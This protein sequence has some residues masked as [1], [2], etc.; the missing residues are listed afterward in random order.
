MHDVAFSPSGNQIVFVAHDSSITIASGPTQ[1][2]QV[3]YTTLLPFMNC[4][5]AGENNIVVAGHD[6]APYLVSQK[7]GTTWYAHHESLVFF[8][9]I[10]LLTMVNFRELGGKIDT[11]KKK[12]IAS[13]SAFNKFKQMDSRAQQ[14]GGSD[15]VELTTTHQNTITTTRAYTGSRD[16]VTQFSTSGV[17][18]KLVVWDLLNAGIAG[19]TL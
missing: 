16:R 13:N 4:F 10:D 7:N 19:L 2:I 15:A 11:G 12:E 6:C 9:I 5:W 1:P 3:I 18:G 14:S 8:Y 17:D